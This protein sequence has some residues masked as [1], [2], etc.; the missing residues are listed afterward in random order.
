M[1]EIK[2]RETEYF[3][4]ALRMDQKNMFIIVIPNKILIME[5][6]FA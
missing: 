2:V 1:P 3:D 5:N 6:N 4:V